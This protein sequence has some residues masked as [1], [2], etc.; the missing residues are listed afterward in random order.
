LKLANYLTAKY[1]WVYFGVIVLNAEFD[2]TVFH[3]ERALEVPLGE[4]TL[5]IF[6]LNKDNYSKARQ[7]QIKAYLDSV[8]C[9]RPSDAKYFR[10]EL[11]SE[12]EEVLRGK[13]ATAVYVTD[14]NIASRAWP[15]VSFVSM[16]PCD[17]EEEWPQK[18]HWK[19]TRTIIVGY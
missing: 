1:N 10:S 8:D 11:M 15:Q 16:K 6:W 7:D 13:G 19:Y 12:V 17:G 4:K 5:L 14:N 9:V 18:K 3:A 2:K